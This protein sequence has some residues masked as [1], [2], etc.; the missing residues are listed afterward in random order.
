MDE[1]IPADRDADVRRAVTHGLEEHQIARLHVPQI[2]LATFVV[3]LSYL[4]REAKSVLPEHPLHEPTA[5]EARRVASA[6]A[7]RCAPH[8]HRRRDDGAGCAREYRNR[9]ADG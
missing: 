9:L 3:L 1:L 7:I 2:N 5:I 4:A 8:H 6:V